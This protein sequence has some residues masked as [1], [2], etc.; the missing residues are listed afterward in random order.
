MT[1]RPSLQ[2]NS[3]DAEFVAQAG[4]NHQ[5]RL[6]VPSRRPEFNFTLEEAIDQFSCVLPA[7]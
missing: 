4:H 3:Y 6:T 2:F 5:I 1:L 7:G